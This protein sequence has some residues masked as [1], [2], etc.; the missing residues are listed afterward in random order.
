MEMNVK[1]WANNYTNK[2]YVFAETKP[3]NHT[4]YSDYIYRFNKDARRKMIKAINEGK[5]FYQIAE[6]NGLITVSKDEQEIIFESGESL[7]LKYLEEL[8]IENIQ[9]I[10]YL[11]L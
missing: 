7:E 1:N 8:E 2:L 5:W 10:G 4:W 11:I 3:R 9:Q 6:I